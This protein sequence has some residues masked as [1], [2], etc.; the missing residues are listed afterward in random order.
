ML[1]S[2]LLTVAMQLYSEKLISYEALDECLCSNKTNQEKSAFL[3]FA[4]KATID[5][6]PRSLKTLTD[7]FKKCK[8]TTVANKIDLECSQC[9]DMQ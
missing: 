9:I 8:L 7:I 4:I 5:M 3:I 6:E 2:N 1:P